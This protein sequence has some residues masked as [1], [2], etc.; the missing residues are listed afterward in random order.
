MDFIIKTFET[1]TMKQFQAN[2]KH[3]CSHYLD[4][5]SLLER[6][7][8]TKRAC[9]PICGFTLRILKTA[10]LGQAEARNWELHACFTCKW[11]EAGYLTHHCCF[12]QCSGAQD[13][14]SSLTW[15]VGVST[16]MSAAILHYLGF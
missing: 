5:S 4:Y 1:Y 14:S 6:Q 16:T 10:R 7:K 11:Q 15:G 9:A 3:P 12:T 8:Q 13:Q 2:S